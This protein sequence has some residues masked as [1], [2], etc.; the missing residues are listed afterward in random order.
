MHP[1]THISQYLKML[2]CKY[3]CYTFFSITAIHIPPSEQ[4][5]DVSALEL[6]LVSVP[7]APYQPL[8]STLRANIASLA[9]IRPEHQERLARKL[10]T[11]SEQIFAVGGWML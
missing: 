4:R 1:H 9:A 3:Q 7:H 5:T 6:C 2:I 10:W 11:N 8:I